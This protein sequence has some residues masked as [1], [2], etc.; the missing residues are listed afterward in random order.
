MVSG[1]EHR[2]VARRFLD[3]GHSGDST[4]DGC[5][6]RPVASHAPSGSGSSDPATAESVAPEALRALSGRICSVPGI[7][8]VLLGGSRARGEHTPSSDADLGL[9]YRAPLDVTAVRALAADVAGPDAELTGPGEWGPW[10]DG[11]GWL[12]IGGWPVDWIYRDVDRVRAAWARARR[13]EPSWHQQVGHPLGVLDVS[14]AREVALGVVLADPTGELTALQGAARHYPALLSRALVRSLWEAQ[15]CV[16][17]ARKAAARGDAAYVAGCLFR[18]IGL[19]AHALHANADRWLINEK[20][21]IAA[22]GRIENAPADFTDRAQ[23]ILGAAGTTPAELM[24]SIDAAATLVDE[25]AAA[26]DYA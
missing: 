9:Y 12:T 7:V 23:R 15:F 25:T 16:T 26:C 1:C 20:G 3:A 10:V 4:V 17:I 19:C 13:G 8:G 24:A 6:D 5:E 2:P 14:Y 11:G 21:A 22:A 18:S